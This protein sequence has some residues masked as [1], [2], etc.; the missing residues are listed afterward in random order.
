MYTSILTALALISGVYG[1][2]ITSTDSVLANNGLNLVAPE[3]LKEL[4]EKELEP[5]TY[6][7]WVTA[8]SSSPDETDDTPFI[9]ASGERVRE[10]IIAANFLPFGA[11]VLMPELFGDKVFI[12]ADRMHR[13][14]TNNVD[15]FVCAY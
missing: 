10:G 1:G 2:Y 12:V 6:E 4:L 7:V 15:I 9:T 11:K 5:E 8:Y 14:K 13:R 3:R